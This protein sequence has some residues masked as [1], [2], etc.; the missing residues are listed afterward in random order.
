MRISTTICLSVIVTSEVI[1]KVTG[2]HIHIRSGSILK[3][4]LDGDIVT[5]G[6]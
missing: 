6:H 1:L 5:T 2:S 4:V 3:P